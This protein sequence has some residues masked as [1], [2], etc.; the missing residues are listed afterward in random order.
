MHASKFTGLRSLLGLVMG[1]SIGVACDADTDKGEAQPQPVSTTPAAPNPVDNGQAEAGEKSEGAKTGD[2]KPEQVENCQIG[3]LFAEVCPFSAE[4]L[5]GLLGVD[6]ELTLV[7]DAK[8]KQCTVK[9]GKEMVLSTITVE[10][11]AEGIAKEAKGLDDLLEL[12]MG[13]AIDMG[14]PNC[15][16]VF[17]G[18]A[19]DHMTILGKSNMVNISVRVPKDPSFPKPGSP[20]KKRQSADRAAVAQKIATALGERLR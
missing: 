8:R 1:L 2:A 5:K 11:S 10:T 16:A 18:S 9:Q 6:G 19:Y 20:E 7:P 3:S 15:K 4:E 13:Q 12:G 17:R 14:V